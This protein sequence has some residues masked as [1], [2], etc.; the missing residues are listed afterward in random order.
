MM[1]KAVEPFYVPVTFEDYRTGKPIT[2]TMYHGDLEGKPLYADPKSHIVTKYEN[3][4]FN[5]I[6]AG[7][8]E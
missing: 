7:L 6:D 3:C 2:I 5:L 8:E 4:K 1:M